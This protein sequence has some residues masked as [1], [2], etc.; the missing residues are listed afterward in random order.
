MSGVTMPKVVPDEIHRNMSIAG[1]E[2]FLSGL[3]TTRSGNLSIRKGKEVFITRH[4]AMLGRLKKD[5]IMRLDLDVS[6]LLLKKASMD[7]KLHLQIYKQTTTRTVVHAHP[8][9]GT[10]LS[11]DNDVIEPLDVEGK[12]YFPKVP[13]V[14]WDRSTGKR[15]SKVLK[16]NRIAVARAH[17]TYAVG[18]TM[19][20]ALFW[21]TSFSHS[22]KLL[23]LR[24]LVKGF[25]R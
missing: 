9:Y 10:L 12:Y 22:C 5:D 18:V 6:G 20:D 17:G 3:V 21:T 4:G 2:L 19:D 1:S 8:P 16:T 15:L 13:V 23:F 25:E 14:P 7:S 11:L 24:A